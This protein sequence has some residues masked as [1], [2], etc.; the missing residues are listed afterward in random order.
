M[1]SVPT[2]VFKAYLS[3]LSLP[4]SF[5]H[6]LIHSSLTHSLTLPSSLTHSLFPDSSLLP[7]PSLTHSL[8]PPSLPPFPLPSLT[9]FSSTSTN[10]SYRWESQSGTPF[11][12]DVTTSKSSKND[13]VSNN[14]IVDSLFYFFTSNVYVFVVKK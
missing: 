2:K 14:V 9:S 13:V 7:P 10:L 1:S 11:K 3:L 5:T 6:S 12:P 8:T 4:Y